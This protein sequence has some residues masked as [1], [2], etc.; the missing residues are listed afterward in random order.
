MSK[1]HY[2]T[3]GDNSLVARTLVARERE[4]KDVIQGTRLLPKIAPV[5]VTCV[6]S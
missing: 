1:E 5:P 6:N 4:K 3:T 2:E